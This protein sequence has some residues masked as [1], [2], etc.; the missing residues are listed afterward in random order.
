VGRISFSLRLW[1]GLPT[2]LIGFNL[3]VGLCML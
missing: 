2:A 1:F 3:W